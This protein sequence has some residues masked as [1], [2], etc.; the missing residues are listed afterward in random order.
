MQP[1][2]VTEGDYRVITHPRPTPVFRTH[3]LCFQNTA[4]L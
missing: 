3:E 2:Q 1:D 4:A